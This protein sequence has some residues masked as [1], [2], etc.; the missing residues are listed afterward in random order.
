L[1]DVVD[2]SVSGLQKEA[3][4][5]FALLDKYGGNVEELKASVGKLRAVDST[6]QRD[7]IAN[8]DAYLGKGRDAVDAMSSPT[9]AM[10]AAAAVDAPTPAG[11]PAGGSITDALTGL[12][13][14]EMNPDFTNEKRGD[15]PH[16][17]KWHRKQ[18]ALTM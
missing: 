10:R 4:I 6:A 8:P 1:T 12:I 13:T 9:A 5:T 17:F 2:S 3:A 18:L 15:G 11:K 14:S 7:Y 16:M